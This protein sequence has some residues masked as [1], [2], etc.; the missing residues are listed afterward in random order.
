M[1]ITSLSNIDQ[2]SRLSSSD[3]F[4]FACDTDRTSTDTNFNEICTGC[5]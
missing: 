5:D 1:F 4:L 2:S 3:T